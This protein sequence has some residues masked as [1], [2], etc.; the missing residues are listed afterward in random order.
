MICA[1][2]KSFKYRNHK[3]VTLIISYVE[4][5]SAVPGAIPSLTPEL[6]A[7]SRLGNYGTRT[8][9]NRLIKINPW[10]GQVTLNVSIA[11]VT[12][13]IFHSNQYVIS[14]QDLGAAA[15]ANR[16]RLINWTTQGSSANFSSRMVSN[17]S[18]PISNIHL[19]D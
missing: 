3:S 13:G 15:G 14:V 16:Y 11:P 2:E 17:T 6:I 19:V 9:T 4:G 12:T 8:I 1:L 5:T 7:A 10:T 18:Y